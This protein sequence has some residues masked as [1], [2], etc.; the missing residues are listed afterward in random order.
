MLCCM[1][2]NIS[3]GCYNCLKGEDSFVLPAVQDQYDFPQ[4]RYAIF[5][6]YV[7]ALNQ[8]SKHTSVRKGDLS[9][10]SLALIYT[11]SEHLFI[12]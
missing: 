7:I 9:T 10:T 12:E 6:M 5:F 2:E 8:I 4:K 3:C 11:E 1:T